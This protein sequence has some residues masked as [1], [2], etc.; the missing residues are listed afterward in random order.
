[1]PGDRKQP[2]A[3]VRPG[4]AVGLAGLIVVLAV[5]S[6]R[7]TDTPGYAHV[8]PAGGLPI[9]WLLLRGARVTSVDT[10]VL[11][12]VLF[13]GNLLGGAGPD[14]AAVFAA[15]NIVQSVLAVLLLRRWCPQMWGCGGE[16]P[17]DRPRVLARYGGALVVATAV[18]AGLAMAGVVVVG[19]H[20]TSLAGALWF[21]RNLCSSLIVVTF[22][23]L[24]G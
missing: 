18:G 7:S 24:L 21:G 9:L 11:A 17:L 14:L 1:M 20:S 5:L 3:L 12:A 19:E 8:Y 15:A 4:A 16:A 13:V 2:H 6:A 23:L 22:G 10:V